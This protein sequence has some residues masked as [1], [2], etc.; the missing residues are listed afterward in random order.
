[1]SRAQRV[2]L[3][4]MLFGM[5]L[6][7]GLY[8]RLGIETDRTTLNRLGLIVLGLFILKAVGSF[9][10]QMY[11]IDQIFHL[12]RLEF[13]EEGN[14]FFVTRSRE[15][16][17]LETVYPPALYV[18]LSP[19]ATLIGDASKAEKTLAQLRELGAKTPFK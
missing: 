16:G 12:H 13:V 1:M 19:L 7:R 8:R 3:L 17:S 10:P 5:D 15:F 14:L 2:G 9:Y 6:I 18:F 11:I 4:F